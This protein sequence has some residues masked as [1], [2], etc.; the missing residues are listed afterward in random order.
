MPTQSELVG[1]VLGLVL[2]VYFATS[3]QGV[4]GFGPFVPNPNKI[5]V[6]RNWIPAVFPTV[7][8]DEGKIIQPGMIDPTGKAKATKGK[9][10]KGGK[11]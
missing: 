1:L 7:M 11:R 8:D 2:G 3:K 6:K 9:G 10:G 5:Q 4:R